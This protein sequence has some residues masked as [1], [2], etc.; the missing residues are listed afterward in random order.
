MAAGVAVP[1]AVGVAVPVGETVGLAVGFFVGLGVGLGVGRGAAG[2]LQ[3]LTPLLV[4]LPGWRSGDSHLSGGRV[5]VSEKIE[6]ASA[7]MR[8]RFGF[9]MDP[10]ASNA[11]LTRGLVMTVR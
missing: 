5:P 3:P 9:W 7:R 11:L 4:D 1:A 8:T 10:R 6:S 2:G